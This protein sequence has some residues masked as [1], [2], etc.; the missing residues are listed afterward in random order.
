MGEGSPQR[1]FEAAA[2]AVKS[3]KL[4]NDQLLKLY[5]LYKQATIGDAPKKSTASAFDVKGQKKWGAWAAVRGLDKDQ[6][7][8]QY[9]DFVSG[10]LPPGTL[11][12]RAPDSIDT[13]TVVTAPA[14]PMAA[15]GTDKSLPAPMMLPP[16]LPMPS[17]EVIERLRMRYGGSSTSK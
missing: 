4:S 14:A 3:L 5:G 1:E 2:E 7:Q 9:I 12:Q 6:A 8:T 13:P 10:L 15:G 11:H 16:L 17:P